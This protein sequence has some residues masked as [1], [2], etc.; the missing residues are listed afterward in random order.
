MEGST[1]GN[2]PEGG[3]RDERR[4]IASELALDALAVELERVADEDMAAEVEAESLEV[5]ISLSIASAQSLDLFSFGAESP[6]MNYLNNFRAL[7]GGGD[8][9]ILNNQ[10][11]RLNFLS[12]SLP[13]PLLSTFPVPGPSTGLK[14]DYPDHGLCRLIPSCHRRAT[15]R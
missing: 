14:F 9:L 10:I 7:I 13:R 5:D 1:V 12:P 2:A 3:N 8:N 11:T 6:K 15:G 4:W